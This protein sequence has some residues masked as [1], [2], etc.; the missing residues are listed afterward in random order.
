MARTKLAAF[1]LALAAGQV[2]ET[3]LEA[4]QTPAARTPEPSRFPRQVEGIGTGLYGG[5]CEGLGTAPSL[6]RT[7]EEM[8]QLV[9]EALQSS[10]GKDSRAE[11]AIPLLVY[12]YQQIEA[13][14]AL[15]ASERETL[16]IQLR[17]RMITLGDRIVEDLR[18]QRAQRER[19]ESRTK[20]E[21]YLAKSRARKAAQ[22]KG[23]QQNRT[24]AGNEVG[25]VEPLEAPAVPA[26]ESSSFSGGYSNDFTLP[27]APKPGAPGGGAEEEGEALVELIRRTIAPDSWDVNGGPGSI[28]YFRPLKVL[29]VRQTGEIHWLLGGFRQA[30]EK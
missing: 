25:E 28:T 27:P 18:K 20:L 24:L 1:V 9:R 19:A 7:K 26:G 23:A 11:F 5:L 13:D 8:R 29:V 2:G 4:G 22:Q 17:S 12:A 21:S 16:R 3:Q 30:L 14:A 15:S 6:A 10:F